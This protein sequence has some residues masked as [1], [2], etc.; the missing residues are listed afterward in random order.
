MA[1]LIR[2]QFGRALE[3]IILLD[4]CHRLEELGFTTEIKSYFNERLSPRNIGIL[5]YK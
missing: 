1:N 4:R 2:W 5:A 3:L